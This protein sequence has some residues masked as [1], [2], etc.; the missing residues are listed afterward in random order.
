MTELKKLKIDKNLK[1]N[2]ALDKFSSE[3]VNMAINGIN[4]AVANEQKKTAY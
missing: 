1:P 3:M 2:E 4:E